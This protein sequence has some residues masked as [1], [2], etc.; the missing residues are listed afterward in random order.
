[1]EQLEEYEQELHEMEEPNDGY[2]SI[3]INIYKE[4]Y[5]RLISLARKDSDQYGY[6]LNYTKKLLVSYLIT[7][8]TYLKMTN[9][10]DDELAIKSLKEAV[11]LEHNNPIAHY[12]LG[13][14][15]YKKEDFSNSVQYFQ[16]AIDFHHTYNNPD[17]QLNKQQ[18][19]HAHMYL[20]NSALHVASRTYQELE[21]LEWGKSEFL[22][23]YEI[24]PI[25]KM[26]SKNDEY[27][28][29]NAFYKVTRN[30]VS[31]CSKEECEELIENNPR[32]TIVFYF[33]DRE[34]MLRF[35]NNH[36][37]LSP[38]SSDI[39][40]QLLINCTIDCP[41]TR[42]TFRDYFSRFGPDGEVIKSTFRK[43]IERLRDK[44]KDVGL[45]DMVIV[46]RYKDE[47]AYYFDANIPFIILYRVDDIVGQEI[48][49]L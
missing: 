22:P 1:M 18:M 20:T 16:S 14:L 15:S 36:V 47:T 7:Y 19:F 40:R 17:Y 13:F 39:L 35:N 23:N 38:N 4:M 27:L 2:Y 29:E 43:S 42:F 6:S 10:K 41:G 32:D 3:L 31:T 45:A 33:S 46:T 12:R 8:G 5:K 37:T 26:L 9:I 44:L 49:P 11:K 25:F 28:Q 30:N 34:N 48:T 24:S 21:R